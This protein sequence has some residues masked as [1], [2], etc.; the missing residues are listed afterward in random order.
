MLNGAIVGLG[1][2]SGSGHL[3]AYL[4]MNDVRIVAVADITP[5]RLE[6]ARERIPGVRTYASYREL[7]DAERDLDF[8]DIA[9]P[10]CDHA[11]IARWRHDA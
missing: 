8:V 1:Y 7:L 9:T 2:I 4:Q 10:P 6:L 5:A 11:E 3:P